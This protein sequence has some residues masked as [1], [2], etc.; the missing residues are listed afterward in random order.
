MSH[1]GRLPDFI[2]IGARKSATSTLPKQ[3]SAQPGIFMSTP[4]EPN[5]FS[6][7]A[8]YVQ[9]LDWYKGLFSEAPDN[10]ICGESSTHYTKLPDY[11]RTIERL[12]AAIPNPK[13]IYVMRDPVDRLIS[14]YIHQWSEGVISCDINK[15]IDRYPELIHYSCYGMQ[16]RPFI[17]AFGRESIMPIFFH[18]LKA[19]PQSQ[20]EAVGRFIGV[21][22][23]TS[24]R[25]DWD[26]SQDNIS[27]QRIR[28][29]YGYNLMI[30]SP[31]M[32]WL[33]RKLVP[34]GLRDRVKGYLRMEQR[35]EISEAQLT[36]ITD[37]FDQDFK[38]LKDWLGFELSCQNFN[39]AVDSGN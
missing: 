28:K 24:L 13:L 32:E 1:A 4:K 27:G 12:K 18:Q 22:D 3:L 23:P 17:E 21:A 25:W 7:D 11:P 6:D 19:T 38:Q 39:R 20:L 16:I 31:P 2:I 33:R 5:F 8:V 30:K 15:A 37:I 10:A 29:F 14:H 9:G 35:P 26:N 34:Q 36:R